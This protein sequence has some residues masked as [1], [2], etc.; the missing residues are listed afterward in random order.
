MRGRVWLML[1]IGLA[2]MGVFWWFTWESE[3]A[4]LAA[5]AATTGCADA[6]P[7]GERVTCPATHPI[8]WHGAR[9]P[10]GVCVAQCTFVS[11]C[12]PNWCCVPQDDGTRE[13]RPSIACPAGAPRAQ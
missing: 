1:V 11:S 10:K 12:P 5:D 7:A 2:A 13:C 9:T 3:Q 4:K 8:C 6:V